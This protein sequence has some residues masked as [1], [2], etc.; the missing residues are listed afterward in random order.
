MP[1]RGGDG[2]E[3]AITVLN[4][5][6][7]TIMSIF[8]PDLFQL[9]NMQG[10]RGKTNLRTVIS[11]TGTRTTYPAL[12]VQIRLA[13]VDNTQMSGWINEQVVVKPPMEGVPRP[14]GGTIRQFM[15]LATT[16]GN[17]KLAVSSTVP[18][19]VRALA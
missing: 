17:T 14:S 9:G 19:L 15:Y 6:G 2:T 1:H 7:S 16:P 8:T 5:T 3:L 18:E 11:A 12:L 13:N 4:D 10:Y